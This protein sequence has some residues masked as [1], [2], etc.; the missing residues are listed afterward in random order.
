MSVLTGCSYDER[1]SLGRHEQPSPMAPI[2]PAFGEGSAGSAAPVPGEPAGDPPEPDVDPASAAPPV[3]PPR[4]PFMP[5]HDAGA[6]SAGAPSTDTDADAATASPRCVPGAYAAELWCAVD[7]ATLPPGSDPRASEPMQAALSFTVEPSVTP[8]WLEIRGA[9]L[10]FEF[11][12]SSFFGRLAGG[13]DC[14]SSEFR[15]DIVEGSYASL[16]ASTPMPARFEGEIEGR[17]DPAAP[18]LAGSWWHGP[19]GA[20][21][22]APSCVGSWTA[23]PQPR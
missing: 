15:A 6:P 5:Q 9:A 20:P 2:A 22:G 17:L 4:A 11:M 13:L 1:L 23:R 18:M 14:A 21:P 3:P 8:Q 10:M 12:G 16:F 19:A 7:P